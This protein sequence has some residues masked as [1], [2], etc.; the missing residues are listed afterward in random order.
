[1][2]AITPEELALLDTLRQRMLG[3]SVQGPAGNR[4]YSI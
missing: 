4:L 1:M 3:S 2:P